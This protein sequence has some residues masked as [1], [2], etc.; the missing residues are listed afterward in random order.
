MTLNNDILSVEL[1]EEET[2]ALQ[3]PHCLQ[4]LRIEMGGE[5]KSLKGRIAGLIEPEFH[6]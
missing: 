5:L 2:K 1:P 4:N 6:Q 3:S